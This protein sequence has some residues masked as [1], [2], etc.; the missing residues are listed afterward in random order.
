MVFF[1]SYSYAA[2]FL[3]L[4]SSTSALPAAIILPSS[5]LWD[6]AA[7]AAIGRTIPLEFPI[8]AKP[9]IQPILD[10]SFENTLYSF[11]WDMYLSA[12]CCSNVLDCFLASCTCSTVTSLAFSSTAT[13]P[14]A[15]T[16]PPRSLSLSVKASFFPALRCASLITSATASF[17]KCGILSSFLT[18]C[19]TN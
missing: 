6:G 8:T 14:A 12:I 9:L 10:P 4:Y 16:S 17:V 7:S 5:L 15:L 13:S 3:F 2:P 18:S 1:Y 11:L 19:A